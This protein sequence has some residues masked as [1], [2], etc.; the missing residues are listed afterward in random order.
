MKSRSIIKKVTV[1]VFIVLVLFVFTTFIIDGIQEPH[2]WAEIADERSDLAYIELSNGETRYSYLQN[3]SSNILVYIHGG[4]MLGSEVWKKNHEIYQ[5]LHW[6]ALLFDHYGKGYSTREIKNYDYQLLYDQFEE[7][8]DSL[9]LLDRPIH[10]VANSVAAMTAVDYFVANANKVEKVI[11]ISPSLFGD[12]EPNFILRTPILS[13]LLMTYY[14]YPRYLDKRKK[15]FQDM[16]AYQEYI[17]ILNEFK[18][19]EGFKRIYLDTWLNVITHS[20]ENKLGDIDE[21]STKKFMIIYGEQDP[22]CS[23]LL[24]E[25]LNRFLPEAKFLKVENTGH[26]PNFEKPDFVNNNIIEFLKSE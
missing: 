10:L 14:W 25:K 11:L 24:I 2:S 21:A 16:E 13:D 19:I 9:E 4:G 12:F 7:L 23:E 18:H 20:V 22:Y 26:T 5:E 8:L 6:S 1:L 15:E 17:N 3:D